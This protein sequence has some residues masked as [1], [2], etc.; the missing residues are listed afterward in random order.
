MV[1]SDL[2]LIMLEYESPVYRSPTQHDLDTCYV[3]G[4][5][6]Q[7]TDEYYC[8]CSIAY[9]DSGGADRSRNIVYIPRKQ[10]RSVYPLL[11]H[12][13]YPEREP[14]TEGPP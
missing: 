4:W 8:L 11:I 3:V 14:A 5:E 13:E 9:T 12:D 2:P 6:F 1:P 7:S 10:V